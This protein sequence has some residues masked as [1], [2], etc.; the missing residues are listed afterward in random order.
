MKDGRPSIDGDGNTAD[1]ALV[2]G[3]QMIRLGI[4]ATTV[5]V[6]AS[7]VIACQSTNPRPSQVVWGDRVP[8]AL[9]PAVADQPVVARGSNTVTLLPISP[10]GAQIG[11]AYGYDM[12]H[13]GINSPIDV[14]G[15]F[16]DAVA[17]PADPVEFDGQPGSF[18]L[19]TATQATFTA[20][21]GKVVALTQHTGA[22]EFP[23]CF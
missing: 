23:F 8:T 9:P 18:R 16:W 11:V 3:I 2:M 22:K 12:P 21:N 1:S 6:A 17:V 15:S 4:R 20:T 13:C 14:D 10:T 19:V 7:V 5:I